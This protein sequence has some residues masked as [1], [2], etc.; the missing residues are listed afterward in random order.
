MRPFWG[1][2][3]SSLECWRRFSPP[4]IRSPARECSKLQEGPVSQR[5]AKAPPSPEAVGNASVVGK[6]KGGVEAEAASSAERDRR[7]ALAEEA[8]RAQRLWETLVPERNWGLNSPA[9][10]AMLVL[11]VTLHLYNNNREEKLAREN[12]DRT[13]EE[14]VML[15][16]ALE[17]RDR[18]RR[19]QSGSS[20][21]DGEASKEASAERPF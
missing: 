20:E 5:W 7:L 17:A 14:Q 21:G 4:L 8:R 11:L 6:G 2:L 13:L 1:R 19:T 9:F 16:R 18:R 15:R 3:L 12:S 10:W